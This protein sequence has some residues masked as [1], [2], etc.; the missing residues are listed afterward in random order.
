M[1]KT[2]VIVDDFENTKLII[3]S[4]VKKI[5]DINTLLEKVCKNTLE[6]VCEL[7]IF[8]RKN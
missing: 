2:I 3:S 4:T 7:I 8:P 5:Q 1:N 6:K